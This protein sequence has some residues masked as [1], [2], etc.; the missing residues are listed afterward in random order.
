M[1]IRVLHTGKRDGALPF[2]RRLRCYRI[3]RNSPR[4][5]FRGADT[6]GDRDPGTGEIPDTSGELGE[7]SQEKSVETSGVCDT[8]VEPFEG[9]AEPRPAGSDT[10]SAASSAFR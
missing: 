3:L 7:S 4:M 6:R 5:C 10:T 8:N 2:R 9:V 1:Y